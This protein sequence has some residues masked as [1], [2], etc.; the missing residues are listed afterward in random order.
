MQVGS[1]VLLGLYLIVK[2]LGPEWI[3][4]LLTWYFGV[5]GVGSVWKARDALNCQW[6]NV[7]G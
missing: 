3:N 6:R 7:D 5:F 2:Y 4:F 1:A